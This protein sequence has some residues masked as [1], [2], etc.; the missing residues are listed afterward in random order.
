MS[1]LPIFG[2][3]FEKIIYNRLYNYFT[4]KGILSDNQF[5]FRKGHS[6]SH[7]L[8]HS[9]DII[10]DALIDKKHAIGIFIDL[11][12][13]F[14]TIDHE[15]L[16]EKLQHCGIRGQAHTLIRSY[17]TNREQQTCILGESSTFKNVLYGVPQGS[18]LGPLLFLLYINDIGNCINA[19]DNVKLVLYADD[20]NIFVIGD[21]RKSAINKANSV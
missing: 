14:D 3:I 7:A 17:L 6:T 15:I 21:D 20:T 12:K 10:K 8:H 2:K 5:G 4:S 19:E 16:L 13:A 11:S 1:T 18:V 9:V